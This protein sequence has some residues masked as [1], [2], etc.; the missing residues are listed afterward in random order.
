[1]QINIQYK[2]REN[3]MYL[4]YLHSHSYWYKYLN[5]NPSYLDSFIEK[6]KE[7]N[8]LRPIDKISKTIDTLDMVSTII[9][10]LNSWH[11]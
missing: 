2:L 7:E 6:Y 3:K 11:K 5:R 8:H 10:T 1:M 9:S 4:D